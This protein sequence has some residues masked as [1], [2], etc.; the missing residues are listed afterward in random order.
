[1]ADEQAGGALDAVGATLRLLQFENNLLRTAMGGNPDD[2]FGENGTV[3]TVAVARGVSNPVE[4]PFWGR[5]RVVHRSEPRAKLQRR[6]SEGRKI[7]SWKLKI[8]NELL[9]ECLTNW[10]LKVE[11][12][13]LHECLI[14]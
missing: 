5:C 8:E 9:L 4:E 10:K 11:N 7:E 14:V 6:Q 3:A 12:E 2:W 13:Q 1:M